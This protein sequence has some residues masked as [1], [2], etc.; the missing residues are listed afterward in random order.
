MMMSWETYGDHTIPMY[1]DCMDFYEIR[2]NPI[3][4]DW[5][6]YGIDMGLAHAN[7]MR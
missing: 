1:G 6:S 3:E 5:A 7:T 2:S 4:G